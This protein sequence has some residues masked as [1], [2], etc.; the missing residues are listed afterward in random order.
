MEKPLGTLGNHPVTDVHIPLDL[1]NAVLLPGVHIAS[2]LLEGGLCLN[3]PYGDSVYKDH[4][5]W[6]YLALRSLNQILVGDQEVIVLNVLKVN[7]PDCPVLLLA[8]NGLDHCKVQ[9]NNGPVDS[10]IDFHQGYTKA[11]AVEHKLHGCLQ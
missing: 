11:F 6:D 2:T 10:L 8:V 4:Y 5:I 3:H 1:V 9:V 7:E